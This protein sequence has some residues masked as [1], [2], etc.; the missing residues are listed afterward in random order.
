MICLDLALYPCIQQTPGYERMR[1]VSIQYINYRMLLSYIV[2][3]FLLLHIDCKEPLLTGDEMSDF[4]NL[5]KLCCHLTIIIIHCLGYILDDKPNQLD[6]LIKLASIASSWWSIGRGLGVSHGDLTGL[7]QSN[8]SNQVKLDHV[9]DIW[10][11]MDRQ[12]TWKTILEV[13]MGPLVQDY[14]LANEIYQYLKQES[15]KQENATSK[16]VQYF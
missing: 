2:Y 4:P 5:C 7:V 16:C 12:V 1:L 9:L 13:L 6:L 11:K 10:I 14:A 15:F 8:M 3:H